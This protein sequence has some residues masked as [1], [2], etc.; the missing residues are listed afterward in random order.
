[1]VASDGKAMVGLRSP[2]RPFLSLGHRHLD[3]GYGR[4]ALSGKASDFPSSISRS[5]IDPAGQWS[6]SIAS[7]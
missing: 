6:P 5:L 4:I 3:H 1:M 7:E 2:G